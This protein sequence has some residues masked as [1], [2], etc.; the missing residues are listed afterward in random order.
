VFGS[1]NPVFLLL[2]IV[3]AI[4]VAIILFIRE[5]KTC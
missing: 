1:Y 3:A 5:R 2:G 4:G